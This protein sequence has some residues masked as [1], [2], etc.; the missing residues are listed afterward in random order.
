MATSR[1]A[2]FQRVGKDVFQKMEKINV[3][4]LALTYGSL[5]TQLLRDCE[6]DVPLVNAELFRMGENI[7]A[8]LVD[9][10]LAKT[11]NIMGAFPICCQDF[12][13]IAEIIAQVG[14]KMY[15]GVTADVKNWNEDGSCCELHVLDNPLTEFVELPR[16]YQGSQKTAPLWYSNILCGAIRSSLRALGI[17]TECHFLAD[18][19]RDSEEVAIIQV[20]LLE[21]IRDDCD[22]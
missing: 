20:Q 7:G 11:S 16:G 19:L 13:D 17:Q 10:F 9:E 2:A 8:R 21:Y 14:F 3:E 1:Q 5:V 4:L 6:Q 18:S 12:R 22:D 15:L